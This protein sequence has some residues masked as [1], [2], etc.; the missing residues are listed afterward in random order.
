MIDEELSQP[1]FA[2]NRTIY[3]MSGMAAV[4]ESFIS[5]TRP[6]GHDTR[7]GS[8]SGNIATNTQKHSCKHRM[9]WF[10]NLNE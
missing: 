9:F 6:T 1:P 4:D 2:W 7:T 3:E 8:V 5:V 10:L